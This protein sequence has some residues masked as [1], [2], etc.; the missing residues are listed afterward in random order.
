M[1]PV[2]PPIGATLLKVAMNANSDTYVYGKA[3]LPDIEQEREAYPL[4]LKGV[5]AVVRYRHAIAVQLGHAI[6]EQ[7]VRILF[8]AIA[9]EGRMYAFDVTGEGAAKTVSELDCCHT[10]GCAEDRACDP[11]C[12]WAKPNLCTACAANG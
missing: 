10:C 1:K 3:W 5:E 9:P 12:A 11:P 6:P 2:I 7:S 4:R 8:R